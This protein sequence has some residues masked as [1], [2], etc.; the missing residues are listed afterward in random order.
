MR[1][2][3]Q[4]KILLLNCKCDYWIWFIGLWNDNRYKVIHT[5]VLK[6]EQA[7]AL[8]KVEDNYDFWKPIASGFST[9]VLVPPSLM[10]QMK[11]ILKDFNIDH[12]IVIEDVEKLIKVQN[13]KSRTHRGYNGK[14]NFKEYY[15]H[16]DVS[17]IPGEDWYF[18][19]GHTKYFLKRQ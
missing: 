9:D 17:K 7:L 16:D 4:K 8:K 14:I 3:I 2:N 11:Q 1:G 18:W 19:L 12:S 10:K 15:S 6:Q 5:Q 13:Q